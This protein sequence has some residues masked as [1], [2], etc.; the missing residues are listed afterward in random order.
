MMLSDICQL[1]SPENS[2]HSK[3]QVISKVTIDSRQISSPHTLFVALQGDRLNGHDFIESAFQKGAL[4]ALVSETFINSAQGQ[5]I[6]KKYPA[7][8]L[9]PVQNTQKALQQLSAWYRSN[10]LTCPVLALTGSSGKTSTKEMVTA[11]LKKQYQQ[12]FATPGN[13]NNH[14]GVPLS[15][16]ACP[17]N[18]EV[19]VFELGANHTGE[20]FETVQW[21]RPTAALITNIGVAHIGEFGGVENIFKAKTEIFSTLSTHGTAIYNADDVFSEQWQVLLKN[22]KTVTFGL[23]EKADIRATHIKFNHLMCA[24]FVYQGETIQ[25][26]VPGEHN[27][28]NALAA[29]ALASTL[30]ISTK[31]IREGLEEYNGYSGRLDIKTGLNGARI[32]D[33][34]YNANLKSVEAALHVLAGFSGKRF[35]V[36]GDL[37]ELGEWETEHYHSIGRMASELKLDGLFTYG[38]RCHEILKTFH[39][40]ASHEN[41][42]IPLIEK[43]KN[44]LDLNTTIVIKGS[45]LAQM[46][47]VVSAISI[48]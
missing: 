22:N 14:L 20:I 42:I 5:I 30:P 35:L 28:M 12:V 24:S 3:D 11:I 2:I 9:I 4:S 1:L 6:Q 23:N 7:H 37:A 25:L 34:T 39:G 33:D 48:G 18:S 13:K 16:L 44:I 40:H 32:I 46:E 43:L 19:A 41:N 10:Y 27:V 47:Q 29:I 21:V 38:H 31:A 36:M 8:I 26:A 45:R 15:L 17:E